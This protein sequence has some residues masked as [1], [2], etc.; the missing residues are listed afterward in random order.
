MGSHNQ[1]FSMSLG[2]ITGDTLKLLSADTVYE[3][4]TYNKIQTL[5]VGV[6]SLDMGPFNGN[7]IIHTRF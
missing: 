2:R 1:P 3:V 6:L 4:K 5:P 7:H